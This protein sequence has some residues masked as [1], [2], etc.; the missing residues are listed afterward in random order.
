MATNSP[1]VYQRVKAAIQSVFRSREDAA[2]E[3]ASLSFGRAVAIGEYA[4]VTGAPL[5]NDGW[6]NAFLFYYNVPRAKLTLSSLKRP[7]TAPSSNNAFNLLIIDELQLL[8]LISI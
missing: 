1:T 6:G 5:S 3:A 4:I 2:Q 7:T 8:S